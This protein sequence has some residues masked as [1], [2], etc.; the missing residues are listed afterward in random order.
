[1]LKSS[2]VLY[3]N[4]RLVLN[5][6]RYYFIIYYK[7]KKFCFHLLHLFY[8]FKRLIINDMCAEQKGSR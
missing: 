5:I 6:N 4:Q 7:R 1:M 8:L 3:N 2:V